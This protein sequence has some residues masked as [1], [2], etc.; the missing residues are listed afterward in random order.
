MTEMRKPSVNIEK[1]GTGHC[2]DSK[3]THR[4]RKTTSVA[5]VDEVSR[6]TVYERAVSM[7]THSLLPYDERGYD[8]FLDEQLL[9]YRFAIF[10][11]PVS[12]TVILKSCGLPLTS[13]SFSS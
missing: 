5:S 10:I 7:S 1:V 6:I 4:Q 11:S 12:S 13:A 3:R 8:L 9:T 2:H